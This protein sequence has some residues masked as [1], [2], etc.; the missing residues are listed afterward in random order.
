[1]VKDLVKLYLNREEEIKKI[2]DEIN[3]HQVKIAK[4]K[5]K[6]MKIKTISTKKNMDCESELKLFLENPKSFVNN[7]SYNNINKYYKI[8]IFD[9]ESKYY[10]MEI[11][12]LYNK[13]K[14]IYKKKSFE[15]NYFN[16]CYSSYHNERSTY[17][18]LSVIIRI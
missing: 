17:Q 6:I 11:Y 9:Y 4:L 13:Y 5:E 16:D 8:K 7:M 2:N 10:D 1:M 15:L 12:E 3:K 14:E 18:C